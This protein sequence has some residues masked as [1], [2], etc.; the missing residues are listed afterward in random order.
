[1]WRPDRRSTEGTAASGVERERPSF[2]RTGIGVDP[3]AWPRK[4][5]EVRRAP[6]RGVFGNIRRALKRNGRVN[7]TM[8]RVLPVLP[9]VFLYLLVTQ[10]MSAEERETPAMI[11]NIGK[12]QSV[13]KADE[14]AVLFEHSGKGCLTHFWFGGNFNG[15]ENTRIRYYVDGEKTPSVDM[16]LYLG[17]GIGFNDNQAPWAT[18]YVGKIGKRNGI[19]NNYR[20]PFGKSIRVTAQRS[21][22]AAENPVIWWIIRGVENGRVTLGGEKLPETA[23][24]KLYRQE[25]HTAEPLEEF[26]LCDVT[27]RGA[28]YQV[29]IA[30]QGLSG[31]HMS[32]LEACMRAYTDGG[33][34]LV[35]LSS[36]LEDYFLGTYYF[37]TGKFYADISGLTHFD[38]KTL[39]FSAY[40]FHDEDPLFFNDGLRLTCRNGETEHGTAQGP[41]AYKP[42]PKTRFTTYT[43]VYQW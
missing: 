18:R 40:R 35:M 28:V 2:E 22:D 6:V 16:D 21:A 32:F 13:L 43:W 5:V 39:S 31:D 12:N 27:G 19:F 37:D 9:S 3:A 26:N 42:P 15:V 17:H 34:R 30:A 29:T 8:L 11:G 7:Q 36:G 25:N 4:D 20:I 33:K 23:R 14:E 38:K 1:M 24:L 10:S 41:V